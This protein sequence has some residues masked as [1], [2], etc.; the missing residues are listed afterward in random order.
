MFLS[1]LPVELTNKESTVTIDKVF[2]IFNLIEKE[3]TNYINFYKEY[4]RELSQKL[5]DEYN[6]RGYIGSFP[7]YSTVKRSLFTIFE[8]LPI[9]TIP[10]VIIIFLFFDCFNTFTAF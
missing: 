10:G 3:G 5:N 8:S 7:K 4:N 9:S 1:I 2:E 6:N